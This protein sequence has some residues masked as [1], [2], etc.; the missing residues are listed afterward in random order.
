MAILS[1]S[2]N[3]F[4]TGGGFVC[5]LAENQDRCY[6]RPWHWA[7][8]TPSPDLCR[9]PTIE[10]RFCWGAIYGGAQDHPATRLPVRPWHRGPRPGAV[11]ARRRRAE[12]FLAGHGGALEAFAS[13]SGRFRQLGHPL[14][15]TGVRPSSLEPSSPRHWPAAVR[16]MLYEGLWLIM[17]ASSGRKAARRS[18]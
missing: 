2:R 5:E 13:E 1:I 12:G 7:F 16:P 17:H 9:F 18:P 4:N 6:N 8:L 15:R 3:L 10:N 11:V 14:S